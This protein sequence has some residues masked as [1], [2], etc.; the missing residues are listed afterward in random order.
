MWTTAIY[1][2]DVILGKSWM[3][4]HK[5][6]VDW[7]KQVIN[8]YMNS[9]RI[10]IFPPKI[11]PPK[12]NPHS[13]T[14]IAGATQ[15]QR[16]P[17]FQQTWRPRYNKRNNLR[18][19]EYHTKQQKIVQRWV[20]VRLLQAQGFYAGNHQLWAPKTKLH[21]VTQGNLSRFEPLKTSTTQT[22]KSS[23]WQHQAQTKD[24]NCHDLR[25]PKQSG[26]KSKL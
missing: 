12:Q 14:T 3:A 18:R 4:K 26:N 2:H 5:C 22:A 6:S 15:K 19:K 25:K 24:N 23:H 20:P 7:E 16:Q 8:L 9:Q 17:K 10:T 11:I 13:T 1:T 21:Q